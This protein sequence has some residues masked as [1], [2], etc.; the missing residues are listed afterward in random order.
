ML[1][2]SHFSKFSETLLYK[3]KK[4]SYLFKNNG[5]PPSLQPEYKRQ[6]TYKRNNL[7]ITVTL[8]NPS[9]T[10]VNEE[11]NRIQT[12]L[13]TQQKGNLFF[14]SLQPAYK[15][16]FPRADGKPCTGESIQ[17][18]AATYSPALQAVPSA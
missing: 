18:K 8:G 13:P 6:T 12:K 17:K 4:I 1:Q 10:P 2:V 9:D 5:G 7:K 11:I 3:N 15:R 16:K 14:W